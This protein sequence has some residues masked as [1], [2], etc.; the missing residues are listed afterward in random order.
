MKDSQ[1]SWEGVEKDPDIPIKGPTSP[2]V[3]DLKTE[4]K[5]N[6]Q[7]NKQQQQ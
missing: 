6:K 3:K 5:K 7:T 1:N 2:K 4:E